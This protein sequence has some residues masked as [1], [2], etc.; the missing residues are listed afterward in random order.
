MT[1]PTPRRR[2]TVPDPD[3]TATLL[4]ASTVAAERLADAEREACEARAGLRDA[5]LDVATAAA[6]GPIPEGVLSAALDR[7]DTARETAKAAI[8]SE[9]EAHDIYQ[10]ARAALVRHRPDLRRYESTRALKGVPR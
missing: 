3:L 2:R 1:F 8:L 6:Q 4:D 5:G 9:R 10:R 7:R